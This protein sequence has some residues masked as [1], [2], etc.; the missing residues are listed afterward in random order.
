M[1]EKGGGP[2]GKEMKEMKNEIKRKKPWK[3]NRSTKK[4]VGI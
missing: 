4:Y 1:G 2:W 3:V